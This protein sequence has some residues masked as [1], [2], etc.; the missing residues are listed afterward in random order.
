M[1]THKN[2]LFYGLNWKKKLNEEIALKQSAFPS[3]IH[4]ENKYQY[5]NIF[6]NLS[7]KIYIF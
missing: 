5:R 3:Y 1:V 4:K 6:I 7:L 2:I